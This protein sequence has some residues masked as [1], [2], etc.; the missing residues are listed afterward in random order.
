MQLCT[1]CSKRLEWGKVQAE[2][3]LLT[4]Q[5]LLVTGCLEPGAGGSKTP[6]LPPTIKLHV[7]SADSKTEGK[8]GGSFKDNARI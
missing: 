5:M 7:K 8:R 6:P 3:E 1:H 4:K 2:I